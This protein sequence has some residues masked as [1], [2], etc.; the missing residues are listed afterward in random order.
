MRLFGQQISAPVEDR[1]TLAIPSDSGL[2]SGEHAAELLGKSGPWF[3][4]QAGSRESPNPELGAPVL[5]K[6][7]RGG[8]W[9]LRTVL[10][11][12]L[13]HGIEA[14]GG[15]P[16]LLPAARGPRYRPS[17]DGEHAM[18]VSGRNFGGKWEVWV[19]QFEP[20][21]VYAQKPWIVLVVTGVRNSL[22]PTTVIDPA[23]IVA[24][25]RRQAPYLICGPAK[26]TRYAVVSLPPADYTWTSTWCRGNAVQYSGTNELGDAT[27]ETVD[28]HFQQI[29][30]KDLAACLGWSAVPLWPKG[31]TS[32]ATLARWSDQRPVEVAVPPALQTKFNAAERALAEAGRSSDPVLA[33]SYRYLHQTLT[34]VLIEAQQDAEELRGRMVEGTVLAVRPKVPD[35]SDWDNPRGI[36]FFPA[37][38]KM[39]SDPSEPAA[40]AD[41]MLNY[42]GDPGYSHPVTVAFEDVPTEWRDRLRSQIDTMASV[43]EAEQ[44]NARLR[45]LAQAVSTVSTGPVRIG[46]IGTSYVASTP[47]HLSWLAWTGFDKSDGYDLT[48]TWPEHPLEVLLVSGEHSAVGIWVDTVEGKLIPVPT[49]R[50]GYTPRFCLREVFGLPAFRTRGNKATVDSLLMKVDRHQSLQMSAIDFR[51]LVISEEQEQP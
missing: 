18:E 20:W 11:F 15:Y 46:Q 29:P 35:Q 47:S 31:Y 23:E 36:S 30:F 41:E 26:D 6:G 42:F 43:S 5:E 48:Q 12:G 7:V 49:G 25:H 27:W 3:R 1:S 32:V 21:G 10:Q 28:P 16:P 8:R 39:V 33:D 4:Q 38:E 34:R 22:D 9:P 45:R 2:I 17:Q 14:P 51:E 24:E 40:I 44:R 13:T 37:V 50:P 19:Q